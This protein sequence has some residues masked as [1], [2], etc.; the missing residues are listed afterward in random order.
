MGLNDSFTQ[1][2]NRLLLTDPIPSITK[3]FPLIIQEECQRSILSNQF[4]KGVDTV[5]NMAF[6]NRNDTNKKPSLTPAAG[7]RHR[8]KIGLFCTHCNLHGHTIDKC[9]KLHGYPPGYR[10]K[11]RSNT[12]S[13]NQTSVALTT[14]Y[15][16]GPA[17]SSSNVLQGISNEQYQQLMTLLSPYLSSQIKDNPH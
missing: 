17:T 3:V 5:S 14:Q 8:E 16:Q 10:H 2:R 4:F 11:L 7:P 1:I 9:Y 12:A 15:F 13:I 6:M